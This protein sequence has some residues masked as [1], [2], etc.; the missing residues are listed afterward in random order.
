MGNNI[1]SRTGLN[2]DQVQN[3]IEERLKR[4]MLTGDNQD[5]THLPSHSNTK[6]TWYKRFRQLLGL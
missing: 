2:Y 6:P 4:I 1:P 5:S 3:M